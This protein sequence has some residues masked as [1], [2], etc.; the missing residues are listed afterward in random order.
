MFEGVLLWFELNYRRNPFNMANAA[1]YGDNIG[2]WAAGGVF[3]LIGG[4]LETRTAEIVMDLRFH[5]YS[6]NSKAFATIA[7]LL[8]HCLNAPTYKITRSG[9]RKVGLT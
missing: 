7:L 1:L 8:R 5:I 3:S 6:V 4:D 9:L 2:K